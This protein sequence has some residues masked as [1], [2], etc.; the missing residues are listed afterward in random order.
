MPRDDETPPRVGVNDQ[1]SFLGAPPRRPTGPSPFDGSDGEVEG[2]VA[3]EMLP[4]MVR[5]T[6][7]YQMVRPKK[8]F[9]AMAVCVGAAIAAAIAYA[10]FRH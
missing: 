2:E 7:S 1:D 6:G 5:T 9:I 8:R 3:L 4:Q 10:L